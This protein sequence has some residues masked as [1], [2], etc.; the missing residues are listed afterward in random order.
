MMRT[1]EKKMVVKKKVRLKGKREETDE[2]EGV[3]TAD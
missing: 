1:K 3:I 2:V